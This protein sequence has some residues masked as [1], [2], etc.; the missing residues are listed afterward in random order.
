M[1]DPLVN[2]CSYLRRNEARPNSR[3]S[4]IAI[5]LVLPIQYITNDTN[6]TEMMALNIAGAFK[7][8]VEILIA[9]EKV[10]S[11]SKDSSNCIAHE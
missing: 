7:T 2:K 10:R 11:Y 1:F 6:N 3:C 4:E 5:L 8:H 9:L